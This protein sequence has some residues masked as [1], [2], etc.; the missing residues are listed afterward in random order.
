MLRGLGERDSERDR[1]IE[2]D[3]ETETQREM[4]R[5][6]ERDLTSPS[7]VLWLRALSS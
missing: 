7:L 4:D 5:D 2:T 3:R 1:D 6:T